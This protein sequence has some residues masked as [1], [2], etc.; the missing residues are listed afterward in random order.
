MVENHSDNERKPAASISRVTL[1][2]EQQGIGAT[3]QTG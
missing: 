1:S 2:D 3:L